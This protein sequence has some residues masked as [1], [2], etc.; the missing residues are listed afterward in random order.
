MKRKL[1]CVILVFCLLL[2]VMPAVELTVGATASTMDIS[3]EFL[4]LLKGYE[5][6]RPKPYWDYSQYSIG[7][8]SYCPPNMVEYYTQNPLT[9]AQATEMLVK[10]LQSHINQVR[11]FLSKNSI[12]VNQHQFDAL[13][14]FTYNCGGAWTRDY[15][16]YFHKAV[17]SGDVGN[18]LIYGMCLW[19][20]AGGDYI[21]ISRRMSEANMY[22]NG[23][24]ERGYPSNFKYVFLDGAGGTPRYKIHGYD[25]NLAGAVV[26]DFKSVPTGLDAEGNVVEYEFE[27]WYTAREGGTKVEVLDDSLQPGAVLYARWKLPEGETVVIPEAET[28]VKIKVTV[29]DDDVNIRS[30]P[31]TYYESLG[32]VDAGTELTITLTGTSRGMLFGRFD[33]GWISLQYTNYNEAIAAAL[34]RWGTVTADAVNIRSSA[35][36]SGSIVGQKNTGDEVQILEW[37]H[38]G[39]LMWGRT[40]EGWI[41]LQYVRWSPEDY[42]GAAVSAT[43]GSLPD[44]TRYIL[45]EPELDLTG[46]TLNVTFTDGTVLPLPMNKMEVTG[47][48]TSAIGTNTL[49][50]TYGEFSVTFEVSVTKATVVFKN[51]D[52]TV[53]T[54]GEYAYGETVIIPDAPVGPSDE[55]GES[56]FLGWDREVEVCTG[57][58]EY[59]AVF[60]K[61]GTVVFKN[62]DGTVISTKEYAYGETVIPPETPTRPAEENSFY[63]FVGWDKEITACAGN[64]E[65][66]AVYQQMGTVVFKN[67]DGSVISTMD[68]A[69]GDEVAVPEDPER[70]AGE[71]SFY[72]FAGWNKEVTACTGNAEYSAVFHEMGTVVF[73]NYDGT[74]L[75]SADYIIGEAVTAPEV[76]QRPAEENSFYRFAGWDKEV[77]SCAGNVAYTAVFHQ[78][79]TIV[80]KNYDGTVLSKKD[81]IL[82]AEVEKPKAAAKPAD[83]AGSYRFI[84]WDKPVRTCAGHAEYTA[85]YELVGDFGKDGTVNEEDAIYLLWHIFFPE[86]HPLYFGEQ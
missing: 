72:R 63:R 31:G 34:P 76:P 48:D 12:T 85:V 69:I 56:R 58:T 27:G 20:S 44:K 7:Y 19:S 5:G 18:A 2:G 68:Y 6:F 51:Y 1:I 57:D 61:M 84:G 70:P 43:L 17:L 21:L 29:T 37:T 39:D 55:N 80:F 75:S 28:G 9:E 60:Q 66:T 38:S 79:A 71:N 45:G 11:N 73:K 24:Y 23:V 4:T 81:Y 25:A 62:Y 14:S 82:G 77:T 86:D 26:T 74:V 32:Q 59:T 52:G 78:M 64:A 3:E 67:Y 54:S 53:V 47:F 35:G 50:V 15:E 41:C 49:T 33:G 83:D 16:G 13:V 46:G 10:E 40:T 22:I 65:Y 42:H 8:G 30:G 36:T